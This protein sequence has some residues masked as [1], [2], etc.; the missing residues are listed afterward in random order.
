[1]MVTIMMMR[2]SN[3]DLASHIPA[4]LRRLAQKGLAYAINLGMHEFQPETQFRL[5]SYQHDPKVPGLGFLFKSR[6]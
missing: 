5:Y 3:N 4:T 2:E 1:M 6:A